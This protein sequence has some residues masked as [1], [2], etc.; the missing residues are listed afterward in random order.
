MK[1]PAIV[2]SLVF[3]GLVTSLS[4]SSEKNGFDLSNS[5]IPDHKILSGGPDRDGIPAIN[6]PKI[7][8]IR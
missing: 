1:L 5:L 2:M 3:S 4:A 6:H 7:F 8:K